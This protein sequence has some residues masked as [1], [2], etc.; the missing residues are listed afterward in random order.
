MDEFDIDGTHELVGTPEAVEAASR[1]NRLANWLA[2]WIVL[3]HQDELPAIVAGAPDP[4]FTA[5]ALASMVRQLADLRELASPDDVSM[6][7]DD[8]S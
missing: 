2:T 6:E 3:H 7:G 1:K 5:A 8:G 4:D